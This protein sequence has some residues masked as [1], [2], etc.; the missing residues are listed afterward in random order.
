MKRLWGDQFYNP[1]DKK[2]SKNQ[3]TGFVRGFTQYILDPIYKV[4]IHIIYIKPFFNLYLINI[5][6]I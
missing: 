1:K 3:G 6:G 2:W 4:I 5:L